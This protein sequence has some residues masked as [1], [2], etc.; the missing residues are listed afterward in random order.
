M[1]TFALVDCNNFYASCERVFNP[2]L[3]GK[4]IVVLSNNDGCVV[5]RSNEAK[6]L[7]VPMGAPFHE[8]KRLCDKKILYAFSSNYALYGDMSKRVMQVLESFCPDIEIYSIDE[9]FLCLDGFL[10]KDLVQFSMQMRKQVKQWT[11]IPV[12]IG[13][14]PT[15]TLAKIANHIAKKR[16]AEGVCNLTDAAIR[17]SFLDDFPVEDI[18]GV[19][20]RYAKRLTEL[21]IY[22]ARQLRDA[23]PKMIRL[24]FSVVMERVVQELRGVSCIP[25]EEIQPKQQIMSSRSFGKL[26][27]DV[28]DIEEALST[29]AARACLKLRN[30]QSVAG[31]LS[32]F[33]HTNR[34][35]IGEP[36]YANSITYQFTEPHNDNGYIIRIAKKCLG[37]IFRPGYQ[38]QKTGIMLLDL[39]PES[40]VQHDLFSQIKSRSENLMPVLD[41]IN[42]KFGKDTVFTA[43]EGIECDWRARCKRMSPKYTTSWLE[44]VRVS[45]LDKRR[46]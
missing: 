5:A 24:N 22:T 29:Y 17:E 7:G 37:Q 3:D 28:E 36:Q 46:G 25:L 19:G 20:A 10:H 1:S 43:A 44:L 34:F 15:K 39:S 31:G 41:L 11:G 32:V 6:K 42:K 14:G 9:S 2:S 40:F 26:V 27:T 13:I 8:W 4:A 18:W 38:Y 33:I 45:C 16:T 35:R 23:N 12:S 21:N 30:Q